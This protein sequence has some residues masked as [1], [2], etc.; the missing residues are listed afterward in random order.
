MSVG[1]HDIA[2][3]IDVGAERK[4]CHVVALDGKRQMVDAPR[5]FTSAAEIAAFV[6]PLKPAVVAIDSPAGWSGHGRSR[7]AERELARVGIQSFYTPTREK[8]AANLGFYGWMFAGEAVHAAVR[9]THPLFTGETSVRGKSMEVFPNATTRILTG[10]RP[11][12]GASKTTWRRRLL[13]A[14][15]VAAARLSNLDFVDAAL[16]AL[17]GLYA[18]DGDYQVFGDQREGLLITPGAH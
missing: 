7:R 9:V 2:L 6:A 11:P 1:P 15:G 10:Q 16:C 12:A 17:T 3:G 8:A 14:Q 4:G 18:L 13:A 5:R